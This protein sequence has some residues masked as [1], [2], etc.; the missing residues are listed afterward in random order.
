M[1]PI[2][3]LKPGGTAG[4]LIM[5]FGIIL[6]FIG[7]TG[8]FPLSML[9]IAILLIGSG[10]SNYEGNKVKILENELK[11]QAIALFESTTGAQLEA[12]TQAESK[13]MEAVRSGRFADALSHLE[14]AVQLGKTNPYTRF[15]LAVS[16]Y[17]AGQYASAIPI[18]E[19]LNHAQESSQEYRNLALVPELL[20]RSYMGA[21]ISNE[22]QTRYLLDF[23]GKSGPKLRNAI[24]MNLAKHFEETH[25]YDDTAKSIILEAI[26]LDPK[27][28]VHRGAIA[29]L[30]LAR[31]DAHLAYEYCHS[32]SVEEHNDY[33]IKQYA[34]VL[35]AL[36]EY[37]E[38]A[39]QVYERHLA[40]EPLDTDSR[41]R[42]AQAYIRQRQFAMAIQTYRVGLEHDPDNIQLRYHLALTNMVANRLD[43]AIAELQA[44]MR[45]EDFESYKSKDDILRL[46]GRCFA[47]KGMLE[48]ALKLYLQANR[49]EETLDLLY[50]LG[51]EFER[52][53]DNRNA[54]TCWEEI[55]ATDVR[56]RDVALKIS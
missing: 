49:S 19:E 29:E 39:I 4:C 30:L 21:G 3:D 16:Y 52:A 26:E 28:P 56:F 8:S 22:E 38:Q 54:R 35:T 44:I 10:I 6:L 33:S 48:T 40:S 14:D 43:D 12:A 17:N 50:D 34:R 51:K 45:I 53:G 24:V 41:L 46:L 9:G 15:M 42:L 31:N 1:K 47:K 37:G 25:A 18:F 13:G 23:M 32:L 5:I 2:S 7:F 36:N 20:A 11:K 27:A 55:F